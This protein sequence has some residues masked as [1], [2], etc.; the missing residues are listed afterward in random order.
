MSTTYPNLATE[1]GIRHK[2]Y[3]ADV[4]IDNVIDE[5]GV[6]SAELNSAI[7][8]TDFKTFRNKIS[9]DIAKYHSLEVKYGKFV[10]ML[11]TFIWVL[12][13]ISFGLSG[14]GAIMSSVIYN[15]TVGLTKD[16]F[17]KTMSATI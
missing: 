5:P 15:T 12:G 4:D 6:T 16:K 9:S 3:N 1:L 13:F 17:N 7:Y 2:K 10:S 8:K 14:T 11:S